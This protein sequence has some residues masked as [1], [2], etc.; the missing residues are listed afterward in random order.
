MSQ[1]EIQAERQS[2]KISQML[3][4]VSIQ[5]CDLTEVSRSWRHCG[6]LLLNNP[7]AHIPWCKCLNYDVYVTRMVE[8]KGCK[9]SKLEWDLGTSIA[10]RCSILADMFDF[11][12]SNFNKVL[13]SCRHIM[14]L[15]TKMN[16]CFGIR[17]HSWASSQCLAYLGLSR[18]K[19]ACMTDELMFWGVGFVPL[20]WLHP[21][22]L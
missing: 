22:L 12:K 3:R 5:S 2:W 16:R 17:K 11:I 7:S 9:V 10:F 14:S 19:S 20:L 6:K 21:S 1:K 18:S 15:C 8:Q 4:R 13:S